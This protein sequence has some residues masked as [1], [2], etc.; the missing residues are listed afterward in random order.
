MIE[1]GAATVRATFHTW[2]GGR[3]EVSV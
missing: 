2:V 1:G 3:A